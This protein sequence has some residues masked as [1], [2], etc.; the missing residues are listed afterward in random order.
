MKNLNLTLILLAGGVGKRLNKKTS[1]QMLKY[2]N[3]TILE[4]NIINLRKYL[5]KI[6]IQIVTNKND[7]IYV[8]EVCNR[9]DLAQVR[10]ELNNV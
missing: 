1:K 5:K 3:L 9:H 8:S 6:P 10:F 4:M 7:F 2:N